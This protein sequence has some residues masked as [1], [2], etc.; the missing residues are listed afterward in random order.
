VRSCSAAIGDEA[1]LEFRPMAVEDLPVVTAWLQEPHVGPWWMPSEIDDIA[2]AVRGEEAVDP[3][4]VVVDGRAVG[5]F[6]VYDVGYDAEYREACATVGVEAGTAGMDYLLGDPALIGRGIGTA[7]IGAFV[8]DV[9]FGLGPYPAVT[10][11][12]DP[13][14]TAS[15]RVLEKNGFVFVGDIETHWG[16]EHLM[17]RS[18]DG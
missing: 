11:G 5:Y 8:R 12:P 3:W 6:Q 7:A 17:R 18:R 15:I 10:A 13:E 16:P 14:N 9:V 4:L 1:V 2:R